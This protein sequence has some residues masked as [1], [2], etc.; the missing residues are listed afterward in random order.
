MNCVYV[1]SNTTQVD[2]FTMV[3]SSTHHMT[4]FWTLLGWT[5]TGWTSS[6]EG[7]IFVVVTIVIL[8]AGSGFR[9][10]KMKI[11]SPRL[12]THVLLELC[13]SSHIIWIFHVNARCLLWA[14]SLLRSVSALIPSSNV[15]GLK[16]SK[17]SRSATSS[18][19]LFQ[20]TF[21]LFKSPLVSKILTTTHIVL[22]STTTSYMTSI[23]RILYL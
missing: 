12:W 5:R 6:G 19:T 21:I 13:T 3:V 8:E 16:P 22:S 11:P 23:I 20:T 14:N 4:K 9:S 7:T 1:H 10:E 18:R 2:L 17:V 15:E